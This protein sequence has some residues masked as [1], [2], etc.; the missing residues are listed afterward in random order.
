M[1]RK[2]QYTHK[3]RIVG[4][5]GPVKGKQFWSLLRKVGKRW[6]TK[7]YQRRFDAVGAQGGSNHRHQKYANWRLE[8]STLVRVK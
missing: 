1:S 8:I 5:R 6:E 2:W 4:I 3:A 7:E